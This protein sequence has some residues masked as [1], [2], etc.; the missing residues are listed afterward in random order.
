MD[1][2]KQGKMLPIKFFCGHCH[3][4]FQENVKKCKTVRREE[5][6]DPFCDCGPIYY[7][8]WHKNN[9]YF[10][11]FT[12]YQC[13]CPDCGEV[14]ETSDNDYSKQKIEEYEKNK[15]KKIE[16]EKILQQRKSD[17]FWVEHYLEQTRENQ[18]K[19]FQEDYNII[20]EWETFMR[21]LAKQESKNNDK[22]KYWTVLQ[23]NINFYERNQRINVN[24]SFEN[25]DKAI[26][27]VLMKS[28]NIIG[29]TL[30]Y[31]LNNREKKFPPNL[32]H[33][34]YDPFLGELK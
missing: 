25:M 7:D 2:I 4:Y 24:E 8:K 27:E 15:N 28:C 10:S 34:L 17:D 20:D 16:H 1:I 5:F 6:D 21:A 31:A 29:V 19:K 32:D 12:Y 18:K 11:I 9:A 13:N 22:I 33:T 14:C 3:C 23:N 30:E 26:R